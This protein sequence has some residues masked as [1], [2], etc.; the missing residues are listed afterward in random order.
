VAFLLLYGQPDPVRGADHRRETGVRRI[1]GAWWGA[2]TALA[3]AAL[4]LAG[5]VRAGEVDDLR[6]LV[7][8]L[9]RRIG[10]IEQSR[11]G[12]AAAPAKPA[13]GW[14][15]GF[16]V[17]SGDGANTLKLRGLVH[18]D[19][20][21][22]GDDSDDAS[23][24]TFLLRRVRP[25]LEGTVL[26]SVDFRLMPELA[27]SQ[28]DLLDAWAD[29]RF[30]PALQLRFGKGKTPFGIERLQSASAIRFVERALPDNLVPNRDLGLMLH[31]ELMEK[32]VSYEIGFFNGVGDGRSGEQD[33]GRD[34]KDAVGRLFVYPLRQVVSGP[35][36]DLG[37]G[38]AASVGRQD[39]V[40]GLPMFRSAGRATFF[41][42]RGDVLASGQRVRWSPQAS[43]YV[44]PFGLLA[45]YVVSD[46]EIERPGQRDEALTNRAWQVAASWLLT[47]DNATYKGVNPSADWVP[48]RGGSG[49]LELDARISQLD[50]DDD[51]FP[52]FAD[53]AVSSDRATAWAV[54]L[55]WYWNAQV[56]LVLTYEQT[57]FDDGD[58]TRDRET[59]RALLTRLQLAF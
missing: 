43:W 29:V 31:G 55:N 38:I 14:E 28:L 7:R 59:E 33:T 4:L 24:D 10:D 46:Q 26:G 15:N 12:A 34:A 50:V 32:Q 21:I 56:K 40:D 30:S 19:G 53:R 27:G 51:A 58:N 39:G 44:G 49:A 2:R 8:D 41:R 25:I 9:E 45:E 23:T 37:L 18:A 13:A 16:F 42:Y 22:V 47:G 1:S 20:R 57:S 6:Q 5:P 48:G 35:L 36:Q 17:R 3:A 11:G 52:V 54:G